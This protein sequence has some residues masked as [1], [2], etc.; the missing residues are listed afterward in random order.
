MGRY[1]YTNPWAD[2]A[3]VG[4]S[5]ASNIAHLAVQIPQIRL[6]QQRLAQ[7]QALIDAQT[8]SEMAQA[9]AYTAHAGLFNEQAALER[10]KTTEIGEEQE[11]A[12]VGGFALGDFADAIMS[13]APPEVTRAKARTAVEKFM[14]VAR[15]KPEEG[16]AALEKVLLIVAG[17]GKDDATKLAFTTGNAAALRPVNLPAESRLVA[18]S[19]KELAPVLGFSQTPGE[20]FSFNPEAVKPTQFDVPA[21]PTLGPGFPSQQVMERNVPGPIV[22]PIQQRQASQANLT[23]LVTTDLERFG[24]APDVSMA[25]KNQALQRSGISVPTNAPAGPVVVRTKE[26]YNKL[27]SG[28]VYIDPNGKQGRKP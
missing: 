15:K 11:A 10:R 12:K 8:Q 16:L 13:N 4:N 17:Q 9:Q 20:S 2:A 7:Q 28:T 6:A 18:T 25:I 3:A 24:F 14:P 27:P 5:V 19:G 22:S 23:P 21:I 1:F 26:E